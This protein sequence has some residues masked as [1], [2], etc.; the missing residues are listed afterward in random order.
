M[1]WLELKI[2]PLVVGLVFAGA[3]LGVAGLAP[4]LAFALPA[5]VTL[6]LAL[7]AL[8]LVVAA[9]GVVAFRGRRTTVNP[10][11][12]GAASTIVC[13]GVYR[14]S[15]NPMYLGFLLAL[16]GWALYL[17]NAAAFPLVP[18]FIAYMTRFQI[19]PEEQAL[20]AKFGPEFAQYM[21]RVRR[22][23]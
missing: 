13:G 10:L 22:W 9:A 21:A 1:R 12:P 20:L 16:L 2:P 6:A 11:T 19:K 3:M 8:G 18:A 7:V 23:V 17:A 15:R 4:G 14:A 5:R